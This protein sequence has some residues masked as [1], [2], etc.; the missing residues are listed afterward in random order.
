MEAM[1][2]YLIYSFMLMIVFPE[3]LCAK[4]QFEIN[5]PTIQLASQYHS[6]IQ[7]QN[8]LVS[9]KLDGVR[10]RWNGERLITRS[11]L[12][13]NTPKWFIQEFPSQTLD[14]ELW[15]GRN[16]F[17]QV[18]GIVRQKTVD[19][20]QWKKITFNVFDLPLSKAPFL[21]RYNILQELFSTQLSPYIVLID[22]KELDSKKV[23]HD[24][25]NVIEIKRGEGLMLH[26]KD[27]LYE[28]KRSKSLLK[29]KKIYD[30]EAF[31]VAH[32]NGKGK[33]KGMLGAML[34]EM[35]NGTQFKL[36]SGLSDAQR[37]NPPAI[38]AVITYQY[39]GLTKNGKPR[40]ASY[41]RIRNK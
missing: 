21:T 27:S 7:I 2:Q 20:E 39:Y 8:Y 32:I 23:L 35:P 17:D 22:Q 5:K 3:D 14:G 12:T 13:I 38:G 33:Y 6:D 36:G 34:M 1:M 11:G 10:A 25:L 40:F 16:K 30:A 29:L 19:N 4:S 41:L 15:I 37:V 31:V 18:S 24:W 26:H 28:H 9:E